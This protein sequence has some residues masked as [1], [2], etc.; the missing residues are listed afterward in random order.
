MTVQ[1]P[2]TKQTT[3]P[4]PIIETMQDFASIQAAPSEDRSIPLPTLC[5]PCVRDTIM[6]QM[7]KKHNVQKVK[8]DYRSY[9]ILPSSIAKELPMVHENPSTTNNANKSTNVITAS[10]LRQHQFK[11]PPSSYEIP[12]ATQRGTALALDYTMEPNSPLEPQPL[13]N[14]KEEVYKDVQ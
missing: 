13:I 8:V 5:R 1:L 6:E 14:Q 10:I 9:R 12:E 2:K 4:N 11:Q 7:R 3:A